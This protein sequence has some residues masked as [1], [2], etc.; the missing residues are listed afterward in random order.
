MSGVGNTST[1]SE[2]PSYYAVL[3]AIIKKILLQVNTSMPGVVESIN[4]GKGT[5]N[6]QPSI[7]R[8]Y[9]KDEEVVDLPILHNVPLAFPRAG[10]A[11]LTLPVKKGCGVTLLFSQRSL[12]RW[13]SQGGTVDAGDPRHHNLADAIAIPGLYSSNEALEGYDPD[14]I[15]LRHGLESK[16]TVKPEEVEVSVGSG[17]VVVTKAG[18]FFFGTEAVDL[19]A[20]VDEFLTEVLALTVGTAFGPSTTAINSPKF[21]AIQTKIQQLLG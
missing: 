1:N 18:K 3:D 2:T 14:N 12:D 11:A 20:E 8:K 21:I 17:R 19:L 16:V 10:E 6:V 7:K 13:K 9:V 15:V 4:V 5:V